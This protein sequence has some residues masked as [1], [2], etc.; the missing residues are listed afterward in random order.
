MPET[1]GI[2]LNDSPNARLTD[3]QLIWKTA[4][5]SNRQSLCLKNRHTDEPRYRMQDNHGIG[6][7][8][9]RIHRRAVYRSVRHTVTLLKRV[10]D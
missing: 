6:I 1:L 8:G 4:I 3:T 7:Y 2:R 10:S 5:L 9:K